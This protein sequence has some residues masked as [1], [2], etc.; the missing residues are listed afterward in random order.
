[1]KNSILVRE[2]IQGNKCYVNVEDISLFID[3][4]FGVVEFVFDDNIEKIQECQALSIDQQDLI[5][6]LIEKYSEKYYK[7]IK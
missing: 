1:M 6:K 5:I 3:A 4:F 7:T 2:D